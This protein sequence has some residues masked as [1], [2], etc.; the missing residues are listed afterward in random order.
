MPESGQADG[1]GPEGPSQD[2]LQEPG[3]G[4]EVGKG[5]MDIAAKG[6]FSP[7]G[8]LDIHGA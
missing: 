1:P 6:L 5:D 7:P 4:I 2:S 3:A 8:D